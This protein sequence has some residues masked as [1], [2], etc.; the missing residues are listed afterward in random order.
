M[1]VTDLFVYPLKGAAPV[2]LTAASLDAF[3]IR[4]DRRWMVIDEAGRFVTAREQ[5]C[6]L[7]I[8]TTFDGDVPVLS[9]SRAGELRLESDAA[10]Q[11]VVT[12][13]RVW[14]D[15]VDAIDQG[16]AASAFITRHLG[17]DARMVHMPD[18]T[19]RQADRACAEE[20]DRVSFADGFPLLLIGQ[21]SLD[22][23]NARLAVPV[24]MQRFRPNVV[25][26]GAPAHDEDAWRRIRIGAVEC[27]VVK[28]CAR[29]VV[30]T[31]DPAT[32]IAAK[33]PLRTL[34]T[35]RH[36]EGQVWF[37]QN[38][39]HRGTGAVRVGDTVSVLARGEPRPA[40]HG[41]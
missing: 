3:G 24:P 13:V 21:A 31:I 11:S 32:A 18:S 4:H 25:V 20:G 17:F 23:L 16:D 36:A 10:A 22:E 35:Y 29:C 37:G 28:G 8:E 15:T 26:A 39:I 33:E 5:P 41:S 34:A 9:S 7:Q 1:Q 2:R 27:D 30:T 19:L 6:L 40:L 14:Q 12:R 38:L